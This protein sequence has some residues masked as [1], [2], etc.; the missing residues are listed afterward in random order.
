MR[1][2]VLL[3]APGSGKSTQGQKLAEF[4]GCPWVSTGEL[5][6]KSAENWVQ[7]QLKTEKLFDD[8]MAFE[9]L[10]REL[11]R[12]TEKRAQASDPAV[13]DAVIDGFP[14]TRKQ[15]EMAKNL[16][17]SEVIEISVPEEEIYARLLARGREQD[18]KEVVAK[19]IADYQSARAEILEV[20]RAAD[21]KITEVDGV[22]TED[23]VFNKVKEI[24]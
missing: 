3:G 8:E 1:R 21:V 9:L 17:I 14:R 7:E 2:I 24:L 20:L 5:F 16:G 15:A 18:E 19:R 12:L 6:R 22:G 11:Q 4:L 10:S 23:E 13:S